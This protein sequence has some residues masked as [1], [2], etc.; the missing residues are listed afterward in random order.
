[1]VNES[2]VVNSAAT[3]PQVL[4]NR[5]M[6][7]SLDYGLANSGTYTLTTVWDDGTGG[8][9]MCTSKAFYTP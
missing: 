9:N 2:A 4:T 5:P 6:L 7:F 8:T 1:M 3:R